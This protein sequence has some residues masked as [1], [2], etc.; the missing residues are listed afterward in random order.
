[1]ADRRLPEPTYFTASSAQVTNF[2]LTTMA[3]ALP[4]GDYTATDLRADQFTVDLESRSVLSV[5]FENNHLYVTSDKYVPPG[6]TATLS[7]TGTPIANSEGHL[8]QLLS[9]DIDNQVTKGIQLPQGTYSADTLRFEASNEGVTIE[10][11]SSS[12]SPIALAFHSDHGVYH[13]GNAYLHLNVQNEN[14]FTGILRVNDNMAVEMVSLVQDNVVP[15]S[16]LTPQSAT[17][18]H[19]EPNKVEIVLPEDLHGVRSQRVLR[20]GE[21]RHGRLL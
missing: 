21:K 10:D 12:D 11:T 20:D 14:E 17:V 9:F 8:L 2:N 7:M 19:I 1:M 13:L 5:S 18:H 3:V 4:E 16:T 15:P 6:A